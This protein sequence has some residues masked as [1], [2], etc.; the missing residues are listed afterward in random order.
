MSNKDAIIYFRAEPRLAKAIKEGASRYELNASDYIRTLLRKSL[1]LEVT[2]DP[3][4][5]TNQSPDVEIVDNSNN[6]P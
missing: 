6:L 4:Y 1:G 3:D 2:P 5:P